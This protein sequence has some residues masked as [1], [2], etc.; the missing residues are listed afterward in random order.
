MVAIV[1][2][3][4][5]SSKFPSRLKARTLC[6]HFC[7]PNTNCLGLFVAGRKGVGFFL[8]SRHAHH[9]WA[10]F[11]ISERGM[12]GT[13]RRHVAWV[14]CTVLKGR[15]RICWSVEGLQMVKSAA[16]RTPT[17]GRGRLANV[18]NESTF[19]Y[20]TRTTTKTVEEERNKQGCGWTKT[21]TWAWLLWNGTL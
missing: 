6:I 17:S 11:L 5:I 19:S 12:D 14:G 3:V 4:A 7:I 21:G 15:K 8:R 2:T 1:N 16:A 18:K 13:P 20:T 9:Q 10:W